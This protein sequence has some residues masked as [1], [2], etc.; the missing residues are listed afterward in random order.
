V[1][2]EKKHFLFMIGSK[3]GRKYLELYSSLLS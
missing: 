2:R 3:I 1:Q